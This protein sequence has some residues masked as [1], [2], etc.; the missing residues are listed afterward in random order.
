LSDKTI[1]SYETA[2]NH[3]EVLGDM[4]VADIKTSHIQD[5]IDEM[6]L[7]KKLSKSSCH[8]VKVLAGILCKVAMA[9]DIINKNYAEAVELHEEETREREFFTDEE[10]MKIDKLA[11]TDE[12]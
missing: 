10:I 7:K 5:I 3:L 1:N 11:Q 2:W 9:D 8:K 4:K 12:W 6:Y